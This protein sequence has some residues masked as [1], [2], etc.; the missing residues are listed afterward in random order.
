M[1]VFYLMNW[2]LNIILEGSSIMGLKKKIVKNMNSLLKRSVTG[3][4]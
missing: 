3:R 1:T 2:S 4:R